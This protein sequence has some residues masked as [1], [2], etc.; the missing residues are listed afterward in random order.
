ML[1]DEFCFPTQYGFVRMFTKSSEFVRASL[2]PNAL[3][4]KTD[5]NN[6]FKKKVFPT[7]NLQ[8]CIMYIPFNL[9][10]FGQEHLLISE[11]CYFFLKRSFQQE[12]E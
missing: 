12:R 6:T 10:T 8:Y 3:E 9:K 2:E 11:Q 4:L 5:N 1:I 7:L